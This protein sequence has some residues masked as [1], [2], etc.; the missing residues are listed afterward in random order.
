MILSGKRRNKHELSAE[1]TLHSWTYVQWP[2]G[3]IVLHAM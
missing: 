1:L 2:R 3:R